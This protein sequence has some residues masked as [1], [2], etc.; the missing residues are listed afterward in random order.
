MEEYNKN[1]LSKSR[2]VQ[3]KMNEIRD[4][5]NEI[6]HYC[7]YSDILKFY[8]LKKNDKNINEILNNFKNK[9]FDEYLSINIKLV[10]KFIDL[11]R[12]TNPTDLTGIFGVDKHITEL[13]KYKNYINENSNL[14]EEINNLVLD[15]AISS[16]DLMNASYNRIEMEYN[17]GILLMH[18]KNVYYYSTKMIIKSWKVVNQAERF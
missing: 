13:L 10:K 2:I 11:S 3:L 15:F 5:H 14:K 1:E 12:N 18:L 8:Q 6:L 7:K 4:N 9:K 16:I 17:I